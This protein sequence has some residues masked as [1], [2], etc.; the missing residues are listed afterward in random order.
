[1]EKKNLGLNTICTHVGETPDEQFKG[2]VSPIYLSSSYE[3]MD[4]DVKRYPRY[5]N[6]PNQE[7]LSKKI[8]ALEHAEA[9]MIFGSGM[10]AISTTLLAFLK[11]GDHVVVQ[12]DIYGGTRNLIETHFNNY[13]IEYSF[14][15]GLDISEFEKELQP[16]T[17]M[18]YIETPSNPLLKLV[19]MEAIAKLAKSKG[20]LSTIDNTFASSVIQNPI[21]FGIDIVMHSATKY[22]GGHSDICAGAVASSQENMD[23][24]WD[25]AKN[26]GGSLSDFTVWMLERSMKT[27]GIRVKAQQRNAKKLAKFLHKHESVSHVY[28]PGLKSHPNHKIAKKQ[29]KGYG[30]MMSFELNSGISAQDFL[31]ALKMIKPSMS[32]AGIESTMLQPSETSHSSTSY[33][34]IDN[35]N[36]LM[37]LDI[38]A[39]GAHPDDVELGCGATI[40]KEI[41]NG[42][43]VGI[44]DLTRGELGTR[45]SADIRDKEAAAAAKIL[46]V[47]FRENMKFSDGFFVNNEVSQLEI[48][49][50][51]RKYR[52]DIV[53]C[54]AVDDRH[55]DHGKGSKLTSDACFLSGLKKIETVYQGNNQQEWRPKYVYH[56]I[57]W[58]N[59]KPDFVVD[60][61]GYIDVKMKAILAY[62]SQF[63]D[64]NS[65]EPETPITSKN[66]LDSVAY[67]AQDL[68][69]LIGKEHGEGYTVERFPAVDSLSDL[70]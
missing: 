50:V 30:A 3:Y 66:F 61:S 36:Q 25:I 47:E 58:R 32:L 59:L 63:F 65:K 38:L 33:S 46:G 27:L 28:Y 1:M 4:V 23:T 69:R 35:I 20:I 19:D 62:G 44:L 48:I 21:D 11:A 52:P 24:I 22:F 26:L 56:Y 51:I 14:T 31:K 57:Q 40:A 16:N 2:A 70:I 10:A 29:M 67:R 41:A 42:K 18:I 37:K 68:G 5:F 53:L 7:Y 39:I 60:V 54:N 34:L 49:K 12:K 13:H 45:G 8:A 64:A 9:A 6:T 43:K 15:D 55:I 17:K